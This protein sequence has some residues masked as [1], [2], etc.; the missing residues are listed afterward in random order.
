MS[1]LVLTCTASGVRKMEGKTDFIGAP[2]DGF[3]DQEQ[4]GVACKEWFAGTA[5]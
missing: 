4:V 2:D 3:W 1:L 5:I